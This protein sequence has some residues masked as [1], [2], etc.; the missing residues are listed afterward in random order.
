MTCHR[1]LEKE[2]AVG[3]AY[4]DY[5]PEL[6]AVTPGLVDYVEIPFE[7]VVRVPSAI[8][9][10]QQVPIVLHCASLSLAGNVEPNPRLIQQ[11]KH[12]TQESETP[13]LGEHIAYVRADGLFLEIA[14]HEALVC[15][16]TNAPLDD[17]I[18]L[19]SMEG[20]AFNVGYTVSPQL[21]PPVLERVVEAS[22][23]WSAVLGMPVLLENGPIYFEMPGSSMSQV[24]FI[25]VLCNRLDTARLLLD[26][27]HL[28]ITCNNL[29][30]DPIA[31]LEALPL[32]RI[33]EVHLSGAR[34]E[35]GLVW[36]DHGSSAPPLVFEL[37]EQLLEKAHPHAVTLEYNWDANFPLETLERDVGRVR[38][39]VGR[40]Q[41]VIVMHNESR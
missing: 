9:I 33:M 23:R 20:T 15:G 41:E 36:D 30:L 5:V 6:L 24:E 2:T 14:E 27:S 10:K 19:P 26:L 11:L 39:I 17:D 28:A 22:A 16:E 29:R 4:S 38:D 18:G 31:T 32:N 8:E 13:W 40:H 3:I 21:S 35:K 25:Q 1:C 34:Q 7:H 12:W 37:L